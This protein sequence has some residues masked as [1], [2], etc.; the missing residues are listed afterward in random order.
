MLQAM[1]KCDSK[2]RDCIEEKSGLTFNCSVSCEGI[3]AD[4]IKSQ[5][6]KL[7]DVKIQPLVAEYQDFKRN[8]VKHFRFNPYATYARRFGECYNELQS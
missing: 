3:Y 8:H 2:G 4:T 7:T 6:T 1:K 5:E